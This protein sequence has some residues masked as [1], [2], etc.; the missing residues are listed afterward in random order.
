MR[1]EEIAEEPLGLFAGRREITPPW[2]VIRPRC[3]EQLRGRSDRT[4]LLVGGAEDDQRDPREDRRGRAH[5][6]WLDGDVE[7]AIQEA[8]APEDTGS[9]ASREGLRL[10]GPDPRASP[11]YC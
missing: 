10:R 8:P 11:A 5:R 4:G 9:R 3:V 7:G 6:T 2:A 1:R